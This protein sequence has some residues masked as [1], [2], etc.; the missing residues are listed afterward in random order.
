MIVGGSD[1]IL[2]AP[3]GVPVA[4]LV[5]GRLQRLWPQSRFQDIDDETDRDIHDPW[6]RIHGSR[7]REFFVYR[8]RGA[9]VAWERDGA[10]TANLD[11]MLYFIIGDDPSG[12]DGLQEVTMVC[13]KKTRTIR[14]L[15]ADLTK[16]FRSSRIPAPAHAA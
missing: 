5:L 2:W 3:P 15:I 4:A 16:S 7:S 11:T 8:D 1:I 14:Q 12:R 9:V 13:G 10:T 6:V